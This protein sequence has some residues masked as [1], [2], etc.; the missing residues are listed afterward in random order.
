MRLLKIQE[1]NTKFCL[2]NTN[3]TVPKEDNGTDAA[4]RCVTVDETH[5]VV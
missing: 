5:T 2:E 4:S 3:P 1:M